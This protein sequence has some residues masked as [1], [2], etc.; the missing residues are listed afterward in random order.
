MAAA[1]AAYPGSR[2]QRVELENENGCLVYCV[3]L[4]NGLEVKVDAGTGIVLHQEQED[5]EDEGK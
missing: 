3:S 4:S 5:S 2:V 1:R